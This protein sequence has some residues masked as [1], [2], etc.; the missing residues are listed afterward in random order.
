MLNKNRKK[1]IER[2]KEDL[3]TRWVTRYRLRNLFP[4]SLSFSRSRFGLFAFG[5]RGYKFSCFEA[6]LLH[7]F[8]F[9]S[10]Y[11]GFTSV[12]SFGFRRR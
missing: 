7:P 4:I 11:E 9:F 12:L 3:A 8:V 2:R 6:L 1:Q 10:L 5:P